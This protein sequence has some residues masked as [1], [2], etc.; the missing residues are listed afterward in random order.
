MAKQVKNEQIPS[1]QKMT[2][3]EFLKKYWFILLIIIVL[4]VVGAW[5]GYVVDDVGKMSK[6]LK[7]PEKY[8]SEYA[9]A[10]YFLKAAIHFISF[11]G[12]T[13]IGGFVGFM[14]GFIIFAMSA[15]S[16]KRFHRKG[17]E[18]GSARWGSQAEKDIIADTE[19]FYNNVIVASDVFIVL[20]R[21]Q[22]DL[23]AMTDK[24]RAAAE[25]KKQEKAAKKAER[26][27]SLEAEY[28]EFLNKLE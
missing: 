4:V 6:L 12:Y 20:D 24:E 9:T 7:R 14:L 8:F 11:E 21:K 17:V 16:S 2:G 27:S 15:K 19:A 10:E 26:K 25:K 23:N 5:A 18:H 28:S 13:F 3:K 22:R 1:G